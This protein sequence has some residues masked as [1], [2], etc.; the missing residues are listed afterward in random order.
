M[1]HGLCESYAKQAPLIA[2]GGRATS[3]SKIIGEHAW[4]LLKAF[5]FDPR[6]LRGIGIQVQKLEKSGKGGVAGDLEQA[7]LPFKPV[8]TPQ[9]PQTEA[10]ATVP[11]DVLV[12][13]SIELIV[14]VRCYTRG[15][16]LKYIFGD[17]L[18]IRTTAFELGL[19][20][21]YIMYVRID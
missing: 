2:P 3:D 21:F 6:E 4:K 9:K 15:D 13:E 19:P 11:R 7:V 18:L 17:I 5:N 1:G 14:F 8:A 16:V 12:V 20:F 10:R